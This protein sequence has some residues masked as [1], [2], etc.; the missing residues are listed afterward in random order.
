MK[1]GE[2]SKSLGFFSAIG[3]SQSYLNMLYLLASFPLGII[4]FV[5]IITGI[6]LGLG[7]FITWFGIPILVGVMY[8]WIGLAYFERNLSSIL[9]NIKIPYVK[10]KKVKGKTFWEKLKK[11]VS[12]SSTWK[13]L[14]YLIIKFPLGILSFVILVVFVCVT[15][16]LI[17]TPFIYYLNDAGVIHGVVCSGSEWCSLLSNPIMAIIIG[18]VGIVMIFVSLAIFNGIAYVSGLLAQVLLRKK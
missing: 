14:A 11:R 8:V 4:Y 16:A 10:D 13:D 9:L 7:L 12:D 6:A 2:K 1:M 18:V 5:F 15:I 3:R 17:A